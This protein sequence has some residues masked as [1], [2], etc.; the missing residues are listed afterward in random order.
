MIDV[1]V[2]TLGESI[3]EAVISR[4]H[5]KNGD[6]VNQDEL[7]LELE[8][9]KVTLE[10]TAPRSGQ[11]KNVALPLDAYVKVGDVLAQIDET[12]SDKHK[13][14]SSQ[15]ETVLPSSVDSS[16]QKS[17][18]DGVSNFS[19][20]A[21]QDNSEIILSPSVRRLI[22]ENHVNPKDIEA[23]GPRRTLTKGDILSY[24]ARQNPATT[25]DNQMRDIPAYEHPRDVKNPPSSERPQTRK[26]LSRIRIMIAE[27]LK[28]AQNTA[29]ILTTFNEVDMTEITHIR[30]HYQDEFQ[31]L[32]GV[33][34]GF[35]SFFVRACVSALY[36]FP[37]INA[38]IDAHDIVYHDYCDVGVAIGSEQGLIVPVLRNAQDMSFVEIETKIGDFVQRENLG[39]IKPEELQGGTFTISNGGVYGSLLSTPILNPPQSGILGMHKIQKRPMVMEDNNIQV[40][41]MM[42]V[43]LSYDH[44]IVDGKGAVSFLSHIKAMLENPERL[45]LGL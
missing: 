23:T 22:K 36:K 31:K 32:H 40:R 19:E 38:F 17:K 9:D 21:P 39:K 16:A 27:R 10:I 13:T 2:P 34:L 14:E 1:R 18:D 4:W 6:I 37:E 8:T 3:S 7:L 15:Q 35:M 29:A 42:Y 43:A 11:I 12:V 25:V 33:K 45:L 41:E 28:A 44:R 20:S 5:V 24:M 30:T 26:P